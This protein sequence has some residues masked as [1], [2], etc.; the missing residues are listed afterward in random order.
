MR[1]AHEVPAIAHRNVEDKCVNEAVELIV[2]AVAALGRQIAAVVPGTEVVVGAEERR[3]LVDAAAP[4]V[5]VVHSR[6]VVEP[7]LR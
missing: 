6:Q 2:A 7:S 1:S 4:G 5:R 3:S